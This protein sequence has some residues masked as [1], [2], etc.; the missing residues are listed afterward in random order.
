VAAGN[1][2]RDGALLL[3]NALEPG[4]CFQAG[5]TR[6][7]VLREDHRLTLFLG[8]RDGDDLGVTLNAPNK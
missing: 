1:T 6:V 7:L 3:N 4:E 8:D 5:V 2:H